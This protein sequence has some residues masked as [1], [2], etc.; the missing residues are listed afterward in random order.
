MSLKK[1]VGPQPPRTRTGE[2]RW[3]SLEF[4]GLHDMSL[5]TTLAQAHVGADMW[6]RRRATI[7]GSKVLV[8]QIRPNG[9]NPFGPKEQVQKLSP[10]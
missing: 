6:W 10:K 8:G 1:P 2:V 5:P 7:G 4:S 3:M 9:L